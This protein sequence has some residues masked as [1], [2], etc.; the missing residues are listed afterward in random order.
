MST[1]TVEELLSAPDDAVAEVYL[2]KLVHCAGA[3]VEVRLDSGGGK[4]K[5]VFA[6]SDIQE[7][8]VIF[9]EQ[10]LVSAP[11]ACGAFHR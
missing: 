5:G 7:E 11:T 10:P 1:V 9:R 4:G 3:S 2:Q 8:H 6:T